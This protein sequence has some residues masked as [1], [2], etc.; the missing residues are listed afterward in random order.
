MA[1]EKSP[2]SSAYENTV[3][4]RSGAYAAPRRR[5]ASSG[6]GSTSFPG[7][8]RPSG[9]QIA[10]NSRKAPTRSS[11]Y[12]FGSSSARACP[13]PCSPGERSAVGD[14]E[15]RRLGDERAVFPDAGGRL[16]IEVGPR[17]D[18]CLA[19]VAVEMSAVAVPRQER[20]EVA[21][22]PAELFRRDRG[23]LPALPRQR[24]PGSVRRRAEGG[25]ADAPHPPLLLRGLD[26]AGADA[27]RGAQLPGQRPRLLERGL[28]VLGAELDEEPAAPRRQPVEDLREEPRPPLRGDEPVV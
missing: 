7:F 27:R 22:V 8:I 16:E 20:P 21:Q 3:A 17:V 28:G 9:S 10:L 15:V 19:E 25:L 2:P 5:S 24:L 26:D 4:G 13:S 23:V 12:I 14:D 18:A 1:R 11:P 6:L